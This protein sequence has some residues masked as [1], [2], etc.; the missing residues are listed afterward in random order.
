MGCKLFMC[1]T[2]SFYFSNSPKQASR[3]VRCSR[4]VQQSTPPPSVGPACPERNAEGGGGN[5]LIALS[6]LGPHE[7]DRFV[8]PIII[9]VMIWKHVLNSVE[10][11]VF[12]CFGQAELFA[13][14]TFYSGTKHHTHTHMF[15]YSKCSLGARP[16]MSMSAHLMHHYNTPIGPIHLNT[17]QCN[18]Q[19]THTQ[20]HHQHKHN[21]RQHTIQHTQSGPRHVLIITM[22]FIQMDI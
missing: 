7:S 21:T 13:H 5:L 14:H 10:L 19:Y 1:K 15:F 6:R 12:T 16:K 17:T 18:T 3:S 20:L 11:S 9:Q 4:R 2:F 22:H 8:I